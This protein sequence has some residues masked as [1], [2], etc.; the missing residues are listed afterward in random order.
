MEILKSASLAAVSALAAF[1]SAASAAPVVST[2]AIVNN[3]DASATFDLLATQS[4]DSATYS[5]G[6]LAVRSTGTTFTTG[7]DAFGFGV[8]ETGI[9]YTAGNFGFVEIFSVA[10]DDFS[11]LDVLVGDGNTGFGCCRSGGQTPTNIVYEVEQD[12]VVVAS[13]FI[14]T[15]VGTV[16]AVT[17]AQGFDLVRIAAWPGLQS[18]GGFQAIAIDDVNVNYVSTTPSPVPVPAAALLFAPALAGF[19][20]RRKRR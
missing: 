3:P 19:A 16:F 13:G 17:N 7:F 11:A 4:V 20:V 18:L 5:E 2:G 6:D 1:A 12:G 14:E 9:F 15:V 10:G 8:A